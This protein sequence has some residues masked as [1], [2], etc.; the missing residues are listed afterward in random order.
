M[1]PSD[2]ARLSRFLGGKSE[3]FGVDDLQGLL[4]QISFAIMMVFMIAFFLFR[5][6][7]TR[8]R[9]EQVLELNRQKLVLAADTVEQAYRARYGLAVLMPAKPDGSRAFDPA[10]V[11]PD[12][13]LTAASA[14][15]AAFTG[16][17]KA[18]AED[19]AS[20]EAL[21]QAWRD[22][23]LQTSG[24]PPS[25]ITPADSFWLDG[26]LAAGIEG[27]RTDLRGLQRS[28]AAR[29]QRHWLKVPAAV[30]DSSLARLIADLNGA[31]EAKRLSLAS[32]LSYTLKARS[33]SRLSELAGA[34]ML[35]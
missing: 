27:L 25:A 22:R 26:R 30:N 10:D 16:G 19:Y 34:P 32:E 20:P 9:Q 31:D 18:A 21:R 15:R 35:P 11:L 2:Q 1:N 12:G 6:Q 13:S 23:I 24:L 14:A 33:L 8:D 17:A 7:S 4:L 28:C 29:L 3:A 5:A